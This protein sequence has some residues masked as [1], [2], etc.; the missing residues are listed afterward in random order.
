MR[1]SGEDLVPRTFGRDIRVQL[2]G[3]H[4][5]KTLLYIFGKDLSRLP[6]EPEAAQASRTI[7]SDSVRAASNDSLASKI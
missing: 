4:V 7:S 2:G 6:A 5:T 3:D 1:S